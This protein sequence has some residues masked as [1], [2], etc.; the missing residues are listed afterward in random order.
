ML[1]GTIL[2]KDYW[3]S[4]NFK[5]ELFSADRLATP[6]IFYAV[7]SIIGSRVMRALS[8]SRES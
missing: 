6:P 5:F 8:T 2:V 4:S 1:S 7:V 3:G